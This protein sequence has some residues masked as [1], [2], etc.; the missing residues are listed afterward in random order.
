M[1]ARYITI[2]DF[3]MN[4]GDGINVSL[5]FSGCE[6]KCPGCYS[7]HTWDFNQGELFTNKTIDFIIHLLKKDGIHKNLSILG[8]ETLS[9]NKIG[10]ITELVKRVKRELPDTKI[11]LWTGYTWDCISGLILMK[12]LDVVIDGRYDKDQHNPSRYKGSTN[13]RV[14]DVKKSLDTKEVVLYAQF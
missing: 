5:W 11:F 3:D 6:H 10:P 9:P 7:Q 14:I 1:D 4:Q 2:K 8:G 12:Y 13:Q